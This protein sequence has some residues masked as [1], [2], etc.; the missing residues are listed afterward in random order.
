[1]A[2]VRII[3]SSSKGNSYAIE[4]KG[5][6]LLIECGIE[7][8]KILANIGGKVSK[9][10]GCL[11]THEHTDHSKCAS[12]MEHSRIDIY[13]SKPTL[14]KLELYTSGALEPNQWYHIGT[15]RISVM[16]LAAVHD[17]IEPYMFLIRSNDFGTI[18]FAT[19]TNCIPYEFKGGIN[20]LFIECNYQDVILKDNI[21]N[22]IV[23]KFRAVRTY[24]QHQSLSTCAEFISNLDKSQLQTITLIHLSDTNCNPAE[25]K[26]YIEQV[27]GCCVSVAEPNLIVELNEPF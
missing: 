27:S 14:Q 16:A 17:A 18:L 12:A 10:I 11:L 23:P 21:E 20:H 3:G 19:D 4:S 6:I 9:V 22:G 26:K 25:C 2:Q 13:S 5:E 1:M 24:E 7:F 8:K 15:G